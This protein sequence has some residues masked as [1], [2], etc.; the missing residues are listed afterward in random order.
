[1]K[2][3]R[4]KSGRLFTQEYAFINFLEYGRSYN[5]KNYLDH[6]KPTYLLSHN[7]N[8]SIYLP[9][10]EFPVAIFQFTLTIL[11]IVTFP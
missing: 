10:L 3:G 8:L 1:M 2:G 9:S 11:V 7:A 5:N 6:I 4:L